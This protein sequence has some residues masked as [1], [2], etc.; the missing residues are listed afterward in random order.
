MRSV[1]SMG[2]RVRATRKGPFPRVTHTLHAGCDFRS[3][4]Q[5]RR[6]YAGSCVLLDKWRSCELTFVNSRPTRGESQTTSSRDPLSFEPPRLNSPGSESTH[7][8][9]DY[10]NLLDF[11]S[12]HERHVDWS[13]SSK[14][15]S[16]W[17]SCSPAA[18]QHSTRGEVLIRAEQARWVFSS[19]CQRP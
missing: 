12:N 4:F 5:R 3:L 10:R 2:C 11:T 7:Y 1:A 18:S 16:I 9:H 17:R 8:S 13:R 15:S 6:K 14:Q 19:R